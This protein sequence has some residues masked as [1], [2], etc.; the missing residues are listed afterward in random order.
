[1][2]GKNYSHLEGKG[3]INSAPRDVATMPTSPWGVV[4]GAEPKVSISCVLGFHKM[5]AALGWCPCTHPRAPGMGP[6]PAAFPWLPGDSFPGA[7]VMN[8]EVW[9]SSGN[10]QA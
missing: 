2:G 3:L 10:N 4:E 6:I 1:M 5:G 7:Q 8:L 9:E